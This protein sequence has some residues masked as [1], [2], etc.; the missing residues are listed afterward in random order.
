MWE[1]GDTL[2]SI[3]K[4]PCET[5]LTENK[6]ENA[7]SCDTQQEKG[8]VGFSV[9]GGTFETWNGFLNPFREVADT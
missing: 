6:S 2:I 1:R 7:C 5:E 8:I 4:L 3:H 9:K